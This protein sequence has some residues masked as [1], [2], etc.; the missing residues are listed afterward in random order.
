MARS[1]GP[2]VALLLVLPG[3]AAAADFTYVGQ[4]GG[5]TGSGPGQ[6]SN[7]DDLAT[8]SAGNVYVADSSNYRIQKFTPDGQFLLQFGT[9]GDAA[10]ELDL[11]NGVAVDSAGNIYVADRSNHRVVQFDSAGT[12]VQGWGWGVD[13]GAGQFQVCTTV[14]ACNFGLA[15][16]SGTNNGGFFSPQAIAVDAAGDV[17]VSE[18]AGSQR[19]QKFDPGPTPGSASFV[20]GWGSPG[21]APQQFARPV[22]LALDS[23]PNVFVADR[24]NSRVQKFSS[25]GG[26]LG[27][28]GSLGSADGQMNGVEDVAVDPAGNVFVADGQN[29][30]VQ[31]FTADGAFLAS[32]GGF[33]PGGGTFV[34]QALAFSPQGDLYLLD[35]SSGSSGRIFRLREPAAAAPGGLPAPVLGVAVNVEVVR[36]TVRIGVPGG[37]SGAQ[38]AQKGVKFVPLTEARQIPVGSF[39]DTKRG[40]VKITS[41]VDTA[42]NTQSGTFFKGLFQV[43]QKRSGKDRG[44]TEARLKGSSFKRCTVRRHGKRR[45]AAAAR[46]K[47]SGRTVRR[48]QGDAQGRFRTRGRHSA[49]TVR[50]TVWT[51]SDRCDGTLTRVLRGK[52]AVRDFRRKR[53]VVVK[54]GKSYLARA[55]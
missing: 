53:T 30:R 34:P 21:A 50:G 46:K 47:L 32:Y 31:K 29:R 9:I 45:R 16:D 39:L 27:T 41:A 25:T 49:A 55:R 42:G 54:A 14:T 38:A 15:V 51:M 19:V 8:D 43:L 44:I 35:S 26:F 3:P 2:L 1:L 11:P 12:F 23:A 40:T 6:F 48:L 18:F 36:G 37:G 24:D 13:T 17:Y 7:P 22:G 28:W 5:V 10:G 33:E 52:V 4:F 20:T